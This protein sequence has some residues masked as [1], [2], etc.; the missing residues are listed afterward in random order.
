MHRHRIEQLVREMNA[1]KRFDPVERFSPLHTIAELPQ[2]FG[3]SILQFRKRLDDL[4]AQHREEFG[5]STL[6]RFENIPCEFAM[7]R[8]L[9]DD[10][11]VI[12]LTEAI[13]DLGELLGEQ[14][15]K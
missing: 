5:K 14:L 11:E 15:S 10:D 6:E 12:D 1:D 4:V 9:L 8:A 7:M 2:R 3:L 13:P